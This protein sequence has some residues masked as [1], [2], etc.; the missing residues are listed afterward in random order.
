MSRR[1]LERVNDL[2]Q[3]VVSDILREL[4][5]PA[6]SDVLF[7][8]TN[9]EVVNDLS[10]A[11]VRVSVFADKDT[12]EKVAKALARASGYVRRQL[13]DR[14]R[15]RKIPKLKFILD[16]SIEQGTRVLQLIKETIEK[17]L[18]HDNDNVLDD[19]SD[20]FK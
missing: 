11:R 2:V 3:E 1:R 20:N 10:Y 19:S 18:H 4:K 7:S 15:L 8:V 9:V 16:D 5:D 12:K 14:V 6:L 13:N 17:P